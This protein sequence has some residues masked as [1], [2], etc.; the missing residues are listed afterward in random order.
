MTFSS[1][2]PSDSLLATD[3]V[4]IYIIVCW[5]FVANGVVHYVVADECPLMSHLFH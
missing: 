3:T 2:L 4:G 1:S 5:L